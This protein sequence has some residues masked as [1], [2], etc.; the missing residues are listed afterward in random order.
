[1]S[2]FTGKIDNL[3]KIKGLG[4]FESILLRHRKNPEASTVSGFSI[5][6]ARFSSK[7]YASLAKRPLAKR[8]DGFHA[9]C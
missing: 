6:I 1:M 9:K 3:I 2:N 5:G 7:A 8:S 4:K